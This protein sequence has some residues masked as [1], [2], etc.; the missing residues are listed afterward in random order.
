MKTVITG[1]SDER[2][3]DGIKT[4][5]ADISSRA[6]G[7]DNLEGAD[8]L[9]VQLG[10]GS[11]ACKLIGKMLVKVNLV[12]SQGPDSR[13]AQVARRSGPLHRLERAELAC[14]ART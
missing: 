13:L 4:T 6:R 3:G 10:G 2:D 5:A 9:C 7:A 1:E 14:E 8:N 11:R 12:G